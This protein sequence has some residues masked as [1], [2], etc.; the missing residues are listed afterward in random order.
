MLQSLPS[1]PI[2]FLG[3]EARAAQQQAIDSAAAAAAAGLPPPKAPV[4]YPAQQMTL[5]RSCNSLLRRLSK[6]WPL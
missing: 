5:L 2:Q 3:S 1:I 4:S 6:V